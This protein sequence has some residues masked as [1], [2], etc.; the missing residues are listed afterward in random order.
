M[1]ERIRV[2]IADDH[3]LFRE[4]VRMTLSDFT[5]CEVVSECANATGALEA[6]REHLPDIVLLD[7]NMPGGGIEAARQI[8]ATYPDIRVIILTVSENKSD[9]EESLKVGASGYV[10][11]GI[12][13]EEFATV[14]E[15]VHQGGIYVSP[16]LDRKAGS[17][18][19]DDEETEQAD[20][21]MLLN[22]REKLVL[23]RVAEGHNNREIAEA[24]SVSENTVKRYVTRIL[25]K[26]HVRNRVE[27]ALMVHD[28]RVAV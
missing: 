17:D 20:P 21:F 27:A 13:G 4:G 18:D 8:T 7:L 3:P 14:I 2:V 16:S 1:G 23:V 26:L 15:S 12:A 28:Q 24:L 5:D 19:Q 6:V 9:V 22:D 25:R 11:K 10:L